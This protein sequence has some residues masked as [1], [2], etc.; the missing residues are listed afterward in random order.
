MYTTT[1]PGSKPD[2]TQIVGP[3]KKSLCPTHEFII[4]LFCA[5]DLVGSELEVAKVK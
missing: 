1:Q 3:D 4:I 2:P 5:L